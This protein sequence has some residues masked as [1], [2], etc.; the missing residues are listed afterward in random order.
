[1]PTANRSRRLRK[2][3]ESLNCPYDSIYDFT[4]IITKV[5]I[6][7]TDINRRPRLEHV[8]L[9]PKCLGQKKLLNFNIF[10]DCPLNL[11]FVSSSF[12]FNWRHYMRLL[13]P[14]GAVAIY[15]NIQMWLMFE[16]WKSLLHGTMATR[17][18]LSYPRR[19][20]MGKKPLIHLTFNSKVK[21]RVYHLAAVLILLQ[22]FR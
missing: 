15:R 17:W 21:S 16:C 3:W 6:K 2:N 12:S 13:T 4:V 5:S 1:M 19:V 20:L 18:N 22:S 7:N 8:I 14:M 9:V 10:T 11:S